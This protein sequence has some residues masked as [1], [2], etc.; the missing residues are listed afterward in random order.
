MN[1]R[2]EFVSAVVLILSIAGCGQSPKPTTQ[3]PATDAKGDPSVQQSGTSTFAASAGPPDC[4]LNV[5]LVNT[6][7][8]IARIYSRNAPVRNVLV[9]ERSTRTGCTNSEGL[10]GTIAIEGWVNN[11]DAGKT[12]SWQTQAEGD[13]GAIDED[14]YRITK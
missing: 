11:F 13:E 9:K 6:S 8:R 5:N 12:P 10:N 1:R 7:F 14:F 4:D 2:M 3:A